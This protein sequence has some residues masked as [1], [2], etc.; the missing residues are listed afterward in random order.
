AV[1]VKALLKASAGQ[2]LGLALHH[3]DGLKSQPQHGPVV[4][5][6]V[7]RLGIPPDSEIEPERNLV[8]EASL[9]VVGVCREHQLRKALERSK[10]GVVGLDSN[11]SSFIRLQ[12]E[13]VVPRCVLVLELRI[14]P[15]G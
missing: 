11:R 2:Y 8:E 13:T 15:S 5:E 4:L 10:G 14:E 3:V 9:E 6:V 12:R 1:A 7:G